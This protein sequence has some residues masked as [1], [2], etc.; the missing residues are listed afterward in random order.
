VWWSLL[1]KTAKSW[2]CRLS[3]FVPRP[4]L[5]KLLYLICSS[6]ELFLLYRIYCIPHRKQRR[7]E[8][9]NSWISSICKDYSGIG[10]IHSQTLHLKRQT[11]SISKIHSNSTTSIHL[12]PVKNYVDRINNLLFP[13]N[14]FTRPG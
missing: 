8:S 10:G 13:L 12:F 9:I 4:Y 14:T 3:N 2:D 5:R 1:K 11:T 7:A 6:Y